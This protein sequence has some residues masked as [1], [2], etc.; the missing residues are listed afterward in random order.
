MRQ[1]DAEAKERAD[2]K[3]CFDFLTPTTT[4][5]AATVDDSP[6]VGKAGI[7]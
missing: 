6:L 3:L 1:V 4:N 7:A 5:F 2:A